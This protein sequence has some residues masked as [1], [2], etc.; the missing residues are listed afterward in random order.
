M[1]YQEDDVIVIRFI[2]ARNVTPAERE[3]YERKKV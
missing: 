1:E 2:N 3:I